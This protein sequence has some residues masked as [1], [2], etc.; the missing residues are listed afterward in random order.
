MAARD[1][2][3]RYVRRI[4]HCR[5]VVSPAKAGDGIGAA[6][7]EPTGR[8]GPDSLFSLAV[9]VMLGREAGYMREGSPA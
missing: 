8:G 6:A 5:R 3:E 9:T 1:S 2:A 4:T 7:I